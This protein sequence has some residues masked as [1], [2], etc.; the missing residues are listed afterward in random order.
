[1]PVNK[2]LLPIN[3]GVDYAPGGGSIGWVPM[4]AGNSLVSVSQDIIIDN[5][6]STLKDHAIPSPIA[7]IK[8][9]KHNLEHGDPNA[10]QEWQGMLAVIALQNI[11][12]YNITIKDIPLYSNP[13]TGNPTAFGKV[14]CDDLVSNS[15]ITGYELVQDPA[16]NLVPNYNTLS[17]FCKDGIPFAMFMP[18]MLICPFKSY[19]KDLFSGLEWYD[20][21]NRTIGEPDQD[22]KGTWKKIRAEITSGP[23]L[24]VTAQKLYL[25]IQRIE[26]SYPM[27]L[28]TKY[29]EE[30]LGGLTAPVP[31]VDISPV[32][33]DY[34][35]AGANVYQPL[36]S[37]CPLPVGAPRQAF[38]EKALFII[39]KNDFFD[40]NNNGKDYSIDKGSFTPKKAAFFGTDNVFV[41]PPIHSD[42]VDCLKNGYAQ[43]S[44]WS[45][46]KDGDKYK[47][48]FHL[49]FPTG[50]VLSYIKKFSTSEIAWT[51]CLPYLSMWPF[52]NF[53]GDT[54]K[55]HYLAICANNEGLGAS[56]TSYQSLT[57]DENAKHLLGKK[58]ASLMS[59]PEIIINL[60]PKSNGAQINEYI[61]HSNFK[62]QQVKLIS[63]TS[64]PFAISFSYVDAGITYSI[65]SWIL[66]RNAAPAVTPDPA[67]SY[68]VAMDFGT[69]ST[70]IYLREN[71]D[72]AKARSISA[73]GKYL[74][75]IYNPYITRTGVQFG[76]ENVSNFIQ[77]YYLFADSDK[78]LGKIFTYGQ[79][80]DAK[81]N[82]IP[83]GN[84]VSN[85]SGR[86]VVVDEEFILNGELG[87]KSGIYNGLKMR[88]TVNNQNDPN[89]NTAKDNFICNALSYAILEAKAEG[90]SSIELR[91]SYPSANFG[92]AVLTGIN[93]IV[94]DLQSI[95]GLTISVSGSTEARAAGEYFAKAL[96]PA[97]QP[98]PAHGYAIIDIGGG[99]TDFS[100]WKGNVTPE[101][102]SEHSFGYAG[103]YLVERTII[104]AVEGETT[105]SQ[106]WS[107]PTDSEDCV[108]ARAIN[109]Y[110]N[111]KLSKPIG[112]NPTMD[113]FQKSATIDF[114]LENCSVNAGMLG[115]PQYN[116]FLSAIRM[117]YYSLFYLIANFIRSQM[118]EGKIELS[119]FNFRIC[120]AGCGS[121]GMSLARMGV[122]GSAFD[123]NLREMFESVLGL[124]PNV[125]QIV[126]PVTNNKE[127]VVIGLTMVTAGTAIA[128]PV[129]AP[130]PAAA[131]PW[132][133]ASA[134][135]ADAPISTIDEEPS[136]TNFTPEDFRQAYSD[137]LDML[138][139]Y[140]L[141]H[142]GNDEPIHDGTSFIDR[143]NINLSPDA[144]SYFHTILAIVDA[145]LNA[146]NPDPATYA[147]NFALLMLENMI[148]QFI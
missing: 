134:P 8:H 24:S 13:V 31:S 49:H 101:L 119:P 61:S 62:N 20:D 21:T 9:F 92:A 120:L 112:T 80:F 123:N 7:Y 146:S 14:I 87:S 144:N 43:L 1:M 10:V 66:D 108:E 12:G 125:L 67:K 126:N 82:G 64:Q 130:A 135:I 69:T 127:E 148:D 54:W 140:E 111:I 77:N 35:G 73:A 107:Y 17:V 46:V 30:I 44:D 59:A 115:S 145:Q 147:E 136:G 102:K 106:M 41:V 19:P 100:F 89:R 84:I 93:G 91:I 81:K 137:L 63:S 3:P 99:T 95:S 109:R 121:K 57:E 113:Y 143:I 78:E 114:L 139:W 58:S 22:P 23:S 47:C 38:S 40:G 72:L 122:I 68:Y 138:S 15:S 29:K 94:A 103:N 51:E 32:I 110:N 124:A 50:E 70:N 33:C 88:F 132:K 48:D 98:V 52:V 28:V 79:N 39:P 5:A 74:C 86:M 129:V 105:F 97:S 131:R 26:A 56:L 25:W 27:P 104:Q 11:K 142:D 4:S 18:S 133:K 6:A 128:A 45:F 116:D 118:D 60:I 76:A 2:V 71:T 85:A 83:L 34:N 90:A 53:A 16:G 65:G 42:V 36:K 117:K 37:V 75:D 141:P 55:Q 96:P